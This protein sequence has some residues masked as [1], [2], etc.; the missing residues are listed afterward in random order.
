MAF[1]NL[2][3]EEG[4]V[5]F[6]TDC[7]DPAS[8]LNPDG[9]AKVTAYLGAWLAE[10]CELVNKRSDARYAHWDAALAEYEQMRSA[11]WGGMS[12]LD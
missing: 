3:D 1:V 4:L 7:Y 10:N 9:A 11:Q 12:L 5:D 8:H 6:E 2:F